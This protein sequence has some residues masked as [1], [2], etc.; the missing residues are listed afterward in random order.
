VN[1]CIRDAR[2]LSSFLENEAKMIKAKNQITIANSLLFSIS[3]LIP[4]K[5]LLD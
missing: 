1:R 2:I 5:E 4:S 3:N